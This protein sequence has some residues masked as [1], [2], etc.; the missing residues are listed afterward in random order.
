M[1]RFTSRPVMPGSA[2]ALLGVL[3]V[4][5]APTGVLGQAPSGYVGTATCLECHEEAA[6]TLAHTVHGKLRDYQY[7]GEAKGCES[8]HG[9]GAAHAD[10]NDPADI[11]T[12]TAEMGNDG[13]AACLA[14][15]KTGHTLDWETSVHAES[16]V[17][18]L[19]CH[20]LHDGNK[21]LLADAEQDVCFTCH[22]DTRAKFQLP[23]HHPLREGFMT[24]S[25]CHD[26]HG[27]AFRGTATGERGREA[28][29]ECHAEHAGPF[30]FE[31]SPVM[32]DCTICHDV[33][34]TVANNLLQQNEP[35][36][37]LQC[38]QP[39][40]HSILAGYTGGYEVDPRV[41]D[42]DDSYAGLS[43]TSHYDGMKASMLTKCTQCHQSIHGSDLPSQSITGQ[44]RA[45]NR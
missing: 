27:D 29:L 43:G 36:I 3:A 8:C 5:A 24:C 37:C 6:A 4:L 42:V 22:M 17:A 31:H 44:G 23:S 28:C 10:S 38:H 21:A 34:G 12:P 9:P 32:E 45:L 26:V 30:V 15:H 33:H 16:D 40:F 13:V 1:Q 14:C 7:P 41:T 18:C 11:L 25:S 35:F 19:S 39:H 2:A 20:R